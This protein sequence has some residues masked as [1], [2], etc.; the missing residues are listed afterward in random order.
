MFEKNRSY[1]K[2]KENKEKGREPG[3]V[4]KVYGFRELPGSYLGA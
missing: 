1:G 3:F 4:V 2:S